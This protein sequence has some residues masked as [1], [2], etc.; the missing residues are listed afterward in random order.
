MGNLTINAPESAELLSQ[1]NP[2]VSLAQNLKIDSDE[3]YAIASNELTPIKA[4]RK[5]LEERRLEIVGPI[6]QAVKSVNDL[7]REPIAI[8]DAAEALIKSS[9]IGWVRHKDE[10]A[11]QARIK[12][13]AEA[14]A[15]RQ[16]QE[17]EQQ[18]LIDEANALREKDP[19]AA[20]A[21]EMEAEI[22]S[23]VPA[24]P[25]NEIVP[26]KE[27]LKVQG[28]SIARPW[29]AEVVDK[30]AF[31]KYVAER[32]EFE[33]LLNVDTGALNKLAKAMKE[34]LK[35]SGVKVFQG[36]NVSKRV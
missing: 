3:M 28:T 17:K 33:H 20:A 21:L 32:P 9:M 2:M 7:F 35:M 16:A 12:A 26:V 30:M 18:R 11:R 13:E 8:C 1:V 27:D 22:I 14:E 31:I 5:A 24:T 4:K 23:S 29:E 10:L 34:N 25:Q 6:N 36:I 19:D 15:A